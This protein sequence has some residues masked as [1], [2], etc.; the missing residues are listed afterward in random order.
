[1]NKNEIINFKN[2]IRNEDDEVQ[3]KIINFIKGFLK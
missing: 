2:G 1:M 3:G